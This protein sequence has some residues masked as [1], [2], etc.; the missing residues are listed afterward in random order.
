MKCKAML[1]A[2]MCVLPIGADEGVWLFQQ[3]PK[4]AVRQKYSFEVSSQF[5]G[6]LTSG[7]R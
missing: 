6:Q 1:L 5:L 3:F 2:W 7:F 4:D